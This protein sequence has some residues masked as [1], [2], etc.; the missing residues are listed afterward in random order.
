VSECWV[1]LR[2]WSR[3]ARHWN[4]FPADFRAFNPQARVVAMDLPG[5]GELH[6]VRSP[7]RVAPMVDAVRASL[8][9]RHVEGPY[10]LLGMSLGAMTCID[11][12][13]R[14]PEEVRAGVL[15][16]TSVRPFSAFLE[17]L[18]PANYRTLLELALLERDPRRREAAIL[19]LTSAAGDEAVVERWARLA[20]ERPVTRLNV[21]RQLVAAA[22]YRAPERP[23]DVPLLILAGAADRLVDPG[24]SRRLARQ[25]SAAIAIHPTAGHDLA[26]DDGPWVAA[27]VRRWLTPI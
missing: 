6:G 9:V 7:T 25:W 1:F 13:V 22:R 5:N 19:R 20:G 26:L 3:E 27:Q 4:D 23:P 15:I 17:R 12:A 8:R 24:C 10:H 18:R 14:H 2:G 21:L 11:W 16:N